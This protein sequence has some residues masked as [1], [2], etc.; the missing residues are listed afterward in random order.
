MIQVGILGAQ[1]VKNLPVMQESQVQS[2]ARKILWRRKWLPTPVLLPGKCHGQKSLAGY[3]PWG[4]KETG[5]TEQLTHTHKLV[6]YSCI[7]HRQKEIQNRYNNGERR[8]EIEKQRSHKHQYV[9][10]VLVIILHAFHYMGQLL[11]LLNCS[12]K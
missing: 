10:Y 12:T 4:C 7:Q 6:Q 11:N 8:G 3:S 9:K 2:W 1:M 5:R